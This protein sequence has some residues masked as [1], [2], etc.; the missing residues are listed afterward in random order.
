ML[1]EQLVLLVGSVLLAT[2]SYLESLVLFMEAM[3]LPPMPVLLV[4]HLYSATVGD[5]C[6]T[7]MELPH[8]MVM[9]EAGVEGIVLEVQWMVVLVRLE[10][11]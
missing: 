5:R 11:V 10:Y 3:E 4:D 7:L 6:V 2:L 9:E 8:P 1:A